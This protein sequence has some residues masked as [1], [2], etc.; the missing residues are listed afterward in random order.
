M[1]ELS[2]LFFHQWG[3]TLWSFKNHLMAELVITGMPEHDVRYDYPVEAIRYLV[4]TARE[5]LRY[6][7]H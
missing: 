6:M 4:N 5:A 7:N 1:F 2:P 3:Q